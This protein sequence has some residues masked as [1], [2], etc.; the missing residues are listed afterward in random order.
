L[1]I[2]Y[3]LLWILSATTAIATLAAVHATLFEDEHVTTVRARLTL[4]NSAILDIFL[5]R[6]L[7][8]DFPRID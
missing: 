4:N 2:D 3:I 5:E 7:Y 1:I 8:A 6:T